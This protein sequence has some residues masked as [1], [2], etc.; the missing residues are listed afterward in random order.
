MQDQLQMILDALTGLLILA[1][2]FILFVLLMA[3]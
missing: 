3:F 1:G 2:L